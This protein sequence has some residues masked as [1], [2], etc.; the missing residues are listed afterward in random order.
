MRE[1]AIK[2][3]NSRCH[4]IK[5]WRKVTVKK[6]ILKAKPSISRSTEEL[7]TTVAHKSIPM[8]ARR[9]KE[10]VRVPVRVALTRERGVVAMWR[11]GGRVMNAR[12]RTSSYVS[13]AVRCFGKSAWEQKN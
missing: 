11:Y 5:V 13:I 8:S 3:G 9:R 2:G 7:S 1:P 10:L 12:Q 4:G 6:S